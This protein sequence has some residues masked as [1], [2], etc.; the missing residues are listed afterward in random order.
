MKWRD[1]KELG[2]NTSQPRRYG[3]PASITPAASAHDRRKTG[4]RVP[5]RARSS[6]RRSFGRPVGYSA[7]VTAVARCRKDARCPVL[8][9]TGI[10]QLPSSS[11]NSRLMD[12]VPFRRREAMVAL[13]LLRPSGGANVQR[14]GRLLLPRL[15]RQSDLRKPTPQQ[16]GAGPI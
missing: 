8:S 12:A 3:G 5:R 1:G 10:A 13:H 16:E 9:H 15:H 7:S 6:A 14:N 2:T 11:A 4:K